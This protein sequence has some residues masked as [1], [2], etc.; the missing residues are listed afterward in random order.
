VGVPLMPTLEDLDLLLAYDWPGNVRELAA[1]IER[2]VI[3]GAGRTLRIAAALGPAAPHTSVSLPAPDSTAP[4]AGATAVETMDAAMRRHIEAALQATGGRI[5]G[6]RGAA[7]QLEINP[8]TLRARMNKLGIVRS[9]F[10]GAPR[11]GD[12]ADE[13]IVTLDEAMTNHIRE[14]LQATAGRIEGAH[15]AARRL[16]INP[17]TLRAR[18]RKLGLVAGQFRQP[19]GPGVTRRQR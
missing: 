8:H 17:H 18:M 11:A 15:G 2:A 5:E 10:R 1:V 9:R 4:S 14:A 12:R 6:P 19:H 7:R 13:T 3:L 16:E